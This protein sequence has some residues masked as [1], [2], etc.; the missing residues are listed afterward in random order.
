MGGDAGLEREII[1]QM[2]GRTEALQRIPAAGDSLQKCIICG[3]FLPLTLAPPRCKRYARS[4]EEAGGPDRYG[5]VAPAAANAD[6][7][8]GGTSR[9]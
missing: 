3:A 9:Y 1:D 4:G 2:D 5:V 7:S 6:G 8:S